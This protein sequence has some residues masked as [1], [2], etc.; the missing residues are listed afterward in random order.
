VLIVDDHEV[1]RIGV[2]AALSLSGRMSIVGEAFTGEE[3]VAKA[4]EL[5]PDVV[6][7]D[8]GL[9]EAMNGF[10][11]SRRIRMHLPHVRTLMFSVH[12]EPEYV[13]EF[14]Q[15]QED[16]Y[17]LKSS[18][19]QDLIRAIEEV[20]EGNSYVSPAIQRIILDYRRTSRSRKG[21]KALTE[22]EV[23]VLSRIAAGKSSKEIADCMH[24][25]VRTV[26]KHREM[27]KRKLGVHSIAEMIQ[28][29]ITENIA[30]RS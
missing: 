27:I 14:L 1:L 8:V 19:P 2:R 11:A 23:T 17:I 3:A 28:I 13:F 18:P 16:G 15:S 12:D 20:F 7:M 9:T 4:K 6:L 29:A 24:L 26:S 10:E 25:S 21:W 22:T 5:H 30:V